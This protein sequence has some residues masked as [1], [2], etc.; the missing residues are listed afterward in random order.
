[1]NPQPGLDKPQ[2]ECEK[3]QAEIEAL[4]TPI[5]KT[6]GFYKDIT[7]I[8]LAFFGIVFTWSSGWF[9]TQ[10]TRISSEK[11]LVEAQTER[12]KTERYGLEAQAREQQSR[13]T[14]AERTIEDLK[15]RESTLSNYVATLERQRDDLKL[16]KGLLE[17][18]VNNLAGSDQKA[19]EFLG[20]LKK[21]QIEREHLGAELQSARTSNAL[22]QVTVGQ[23]VS[24]IRRA[25][26]LLSQ[27][28]GITFTDKRLLQKFSE[29]RDSAA[30]F[31]FAAT[32][33]YP[34][35][36]PSQSNGPNY[37]LEVIL[38]REEWLSKHPSGKSYE[39]YIQDAQERL[40]V[41][42]AASEYLRQ[43]R[44]S[45]PGKLEVAPSNAVSNGL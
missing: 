7:P 16:A 39:A 42:K 34:E 19:Q 37:E 38:K 20:E 27:G 13:V 14:Q 24:F 8:A 3:L 40:D 32:R 33:F 36:R 10:R 5:W 12:L 43:S 9:D 15:S 26:D 23:Q 28:S 11:T 2:L 22:L 41:Q 31:Q 1:M 45:A 44:L 35:W 30:S 17:K 18:Q 4:R 25:D 6:G 29:W 21:L